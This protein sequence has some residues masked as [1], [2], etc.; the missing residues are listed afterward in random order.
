MSELSLALN[1]PP[2]AGA[3]DTV[4]KPD[5]R[6][7]ALVNDHFDFVW[8]LLRRLGIPEADADDA[9]QQVFIVGTRRLADIP[10]GSERTFLYGS[11][12]RVASNMR[13]NSARRERFIR[14]V[15]AESDAAART[16][17]DE[18]ERRQALAF[19]D[20]LLSV[21]DDD[22]REVFV[23][24]EIEE[25]TAPEVASII[26]APVGTV[27][28]RLRRARQSFGEELKRLKAQGT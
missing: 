25:L 28:S 21:L 24:C 23:L 3:R 6:A 1:G 26:G 27:A 7:R 20:R 18:L 12:L 10:I 13:R 11:A 15:P 8:R 22:Q 5:T 14:S 19:L 16:P 4:S 2:A 9:A 17:H